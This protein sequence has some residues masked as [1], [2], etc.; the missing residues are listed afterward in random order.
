[1]RI[2]NKIYTTKYIGF[3]HSIPRVRNGPG[4]LQAAS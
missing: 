4:Y 3:T 1:M 2:F